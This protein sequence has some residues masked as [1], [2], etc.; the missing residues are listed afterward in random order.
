MKKEECMNIAP[1]QK[2]CIVTGAARGIGRTITSTLLDASYAVIMVD[3]DDEALNAAVKAFKDR[4]VIS[5]E[6]DVGSEADMTELFS[7]IAEEGLP[8]WGIV[9]NAGVSSNGPIEELS[10]KQ[11]HRVL[12][13]NLTSIFLTAKYGTPLMPEGSIVNIASTRAFMSEP[14]T[15]AYSASKGGVI[16]LTHSLAVSLGPR[17]RVNAV[18]PGWI[19]VTDEQP[20]R[21]DHL[22]HPA[23]RVGMP[24]DI[25]SMAAYLISPES[26]F[27]T[28]EHI[29]IDGGMTR[30]MIYR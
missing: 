8:L 16:A 3:R 24:Q 30:R 14:D 17:I 10:L 21:E 19:N 26:G 12:D 28:G 1:H 4:H 27:I 13:T 22:Q 6:A 20:T 23:G 11:W 25:A 7:Y 18:C 5:W 9:N 29:T 2:L 15:E